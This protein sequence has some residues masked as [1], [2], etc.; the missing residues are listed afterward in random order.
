MEVIEA[1]CPLGAKCETPGKKDG[2]D[3]IIRCPWYTMVRGHN[4]NT[5]KEIDEWGCAIAWMPAL[6]INAANE[7]RKTA[8]SVDSFRNNMAK[9]IDSLKLV[10]P[11]KPEEKLLNVK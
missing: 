11:K 5:D 3:V 9:G 4:P 1:D 6:M 10:P 2:K 7:S 8:A